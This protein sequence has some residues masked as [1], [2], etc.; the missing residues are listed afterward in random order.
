[1]RVRLW[2]QRTELTLGPVRFLNAVV[3]WPTYSPNAFVRGGSIFFSA[4]SPEAFDATCVLDVF[5][6]EIGHTLYGHF[7]Y[8]GESGAVAEH[9]CDVLGIAVRHHYDR[10]TGVSITW[11]FGSL[12]KNGSHMKDFLDPSRGTVAQA[13][14]MEGWIPSEADRGGVHAAGG[15]LNGVF[16]RVCVRSGLESWGLPLEVWRRSARRAG[17]RITMRDFGRILVAE[18]GELSELVFDELERAGLG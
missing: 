16:A 3:N 11:K 2:A 1:M 14:T 5:A 8:W 6:H 9:V 4:S 10:D 7:R 15:V 12:Y 17:T 18:G 13:R